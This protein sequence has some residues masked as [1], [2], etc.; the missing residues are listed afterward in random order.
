MV[1]TRVQASWM[2]RKRGRQRQVEQADGLVVDLDFQRGEARPAQDQDHPEGGE[3]EDEDQQGGGGDGRH[4][5]RQGDVPQGLPAVGAQHL[6][7][8]AQARVQVRPEIAHHAQHDGGVVED[9][10]DQDG[11]Q[12]VGELDRRLGQAASSAISA[13]LTQPR[14]PSRA[15]KAAATT[16]VGM[17]KGCRSA[18]GCRD[19]PRKS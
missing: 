17:T 13:R 16:R 12:G 9:V 19:L 15:L 3:I 6:G 1:S 2:M 5:Q 14:G 7:G 11:G 8:L 4:Q 10:G 18:P